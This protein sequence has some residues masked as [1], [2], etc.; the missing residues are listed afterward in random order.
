[1]YLGY[2]AKYL[3]QF[4]YGCSRPGA[5]RRMTHLEI[6]ESAGRKSDRDY[7]IGSLD[8][9]PRVCVN[10]VNGRGLQ[11]KMRI[12]QRMPFE[13]RFLT[14]AGINGEHFKAQQYIIDPM[15]ASR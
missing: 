4:T 14:K 10:I 3:R 5:P 15:I 6:K 11:D 7:T 9:Q 1:M 12:V 8:S 13:I 2:C